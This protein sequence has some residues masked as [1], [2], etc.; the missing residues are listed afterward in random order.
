MEEPTHW[1]DGFAP[2][3]V[4]ESTLEMY[5]S[6]SECNRQMLGCRDS[7][8]HFG[9]IRT[10][11]IRSVNSR[12]HVVVGLAGLDGSIKVGGGCNQRGIQF[13]I[14]ASRRHRPINVVP[15]DVRGDAGRP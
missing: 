2:I 11:I 5:T 3:V 7:P 15:G 6:A 8:L 1:V 12:G 4:P 9:T 14:W 10:L 13:G